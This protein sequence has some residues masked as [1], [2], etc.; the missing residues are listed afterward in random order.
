[1]KKQIMTSEASKLL[2]D[3]CSQYEEVT[4]RNSSKVIPVFSEM[5]INDYG[6]CYVKRMGATQFF[7][8]SSVEF[9]EAV[10]GQGVLTEFIAY[11]KANPYYYKGIEVESIQNPALAKSL[12]DKGWVCHE[13]LCD[14]TK[15]LCPT[16]Y[17]KF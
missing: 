4:K 2:I 13:H 12:L 1:M 11:I 8:I 14:L 6:H 15:E 5:L 17:I 16:L 3:L 7:C 10:C 9:D